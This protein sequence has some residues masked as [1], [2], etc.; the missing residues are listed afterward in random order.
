MVEI[1]T[2]VLFALSVVLFVVGLSDSLRD[3]VEGRQCSLK[4]WILLGVEVGCLVAIIAI[5]K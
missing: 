3:Y 2:I 4:G 5:H 1:I